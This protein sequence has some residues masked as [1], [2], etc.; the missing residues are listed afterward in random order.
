MRI[1]KVIASSVLSLA[2]L[3][4]SS[5]FFTAQAEA[6]SPNET[7]KLCTSEVFGPYSSRNAIPAIYNDGTYNWYLKGAKTYSGIWYGAYERC[8]Y[9]TL[10]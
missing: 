7:W 5:A 1:K 2:L 6:A 8:W 10:T 3:V 4:S 9:T